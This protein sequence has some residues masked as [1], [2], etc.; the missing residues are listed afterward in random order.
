LNKKYTGFN[1]DKLVLTKKEI[2]DFCDRVLVKWSKN[3][4]KHAKNIFAM[5]AVKT[6]VY[7]TE[8]DSLKEIWGEILN[9]TYELLYENAIAQA[10]EENVDWSKVMQKLKKE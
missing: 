3:P 7:W 8:E 9:W 2:L 10:N 4:T 1:P 6:S 5:N